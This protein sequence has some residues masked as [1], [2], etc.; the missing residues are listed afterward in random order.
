MNGSSTSPQMP[1]TAE[2]RAR[3]PGSETALR[4][5]R[6]PRKRKNM[7]SVRVSRASQVHQVPQI[8]LAQIGPV[9]SSTHENAVPTSA[10]ASPHR[11]N[12]SSL[13]SRYRM[14]VIPTS[15]MAS[16][17]DDAAGT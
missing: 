16:M 8:G 3:S 7:K 1:T 15:P 11:S 14:P 12:R 17:A 4:S 2:Y 9:G 6:Y 10:E 5:S 13:R